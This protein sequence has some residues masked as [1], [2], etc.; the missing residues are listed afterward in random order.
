MNA[1]AQKRYA[2]LRRQLFALVE[3]FGWKMPPQDDNNQLSRLKRACKLR[4]HQANSLNEQIPTMNRSGHFHIHWCMWDHTPSSFPEPPRSNPKKASSIHK[5]ILGGTKLSAS[6]NTVLS[7]TLAAII[8][9][10]PQVNASDAAI[11]ITQHVLILVF[12][13]FIENC[14]IVTAEQSNNKV[15]LFQHLSNPHLWSSESI[16]DNAGWSVVAQNHPLKNPTRVRVPCFACI[17]CKRPPLFRPRAWPPSIESRSCWVGCFATLYQ[18]GWTWSKE[19]VGWWLILSRWG[20]SWSPKVDDKIVHSQKPLSTHQYVIVLHTWTFDLGFQKNGNWD[21]NTTP[22]WLNLRPYSN[23]VLTCPYQP[24][25]K[26]ITLAYAHLSLNS[27]FILKL[28][29]IS[30]LYDLYNTIPKGPFHI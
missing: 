24:T 25:N 29:P 21:A 1:T 27:K 7:G 28:G 18:V 15:Q 19:A 23:L 26:T 6:V 9:Y 10:D 13:I 16:N 20:P 30:N 22:T 5:A 11:Q 17:S 12:A 14:Q 4:C 8:C 3:V 2:S